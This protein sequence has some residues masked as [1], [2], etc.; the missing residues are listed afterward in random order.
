[1]CTSIAKIGAN[2]Y[3]LPAAQKVQTELS[4]PETFTGKVASAL[5]G[6]DSERLQNALASFQ[7]RYLKATVEL[8][9]NP[10]GRVLKYQLRD[11]GARATTWDRGGPPLT[12]LG[13]EWPCLRDS[14][15][16]AGITSRQTG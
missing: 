16:A 5:F 11:E 12:F 6:A 14:S 2:A 13:A 10:V 4:S 9:K 15:R 7:S 3:T 8:P 1:M